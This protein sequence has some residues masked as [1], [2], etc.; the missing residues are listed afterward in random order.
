[1]AETSWWDNNYTKRRKI[2]ITADAGDAI[3]VDFSLNVNITGVT[4]AAIHGACLVS[5]ADFRIVWWDGAAW[6]ELDRQLPTFEVGEIDV[7]FAVQAVILAAGVDDDHYIYYEYAAAGAPAEDTDNIFDY[8]DHF[9]GAALGGDWTVT[10]GG[11]QASR[12]TVGSSI[13][14]L[15]TDGGTGSYNVNVLDDVT[16]IAVPVEFS[17]KVQVSHIRDANRGHLWGLVDYVESDYARY[18][19]YLTV[20]V[21]KL[22]NADNGVATDVAFGAEPVASTWYEYDL[23]V[24]AA[25]TRLRRDGGGW[26]E[27]A[28]AVPD[29]AMGANLF[30]ASSGNNHFDL[31]CDWVRIRYAVENE[32][33]PVVAAVEDIAPE[34][35]DTG[36]GVDAVEFVRDN[37]I[38]DSGVGTERLDVSF[39]FVSDSG[40]GVDALLV[41]KTV[42]ITDTGEGFDGTSEMY[43]SCPT[44]GGAA[45]TGASPR[46]HPHTGKYYLAAQPWKELFSGR[47]T[48]SSCEYNLT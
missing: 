2:S 29:H 22:R 45:A 26:T 19:N 12:P 7:W 20:V 39:V 40:V 44:G 35:A 24:L 13:V 47:I 5:G 46:N 37:L 36:S 10:L 31:L 30:V 21:D 14:T 16:K 8:F 27:N 43:S 28:V 18:M 3:G 32:P 11:D 9:P 17:C 42:E 23:Q 15:S 1:M 48:V 6:N 41:G 33:V 4:A 34:V 25:K 38:S